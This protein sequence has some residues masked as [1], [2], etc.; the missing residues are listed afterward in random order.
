MAAPED[1]Q[2]IF[3]QETE[4]LIIVS[5]YY[6]AQKGFVKIPKTGEEARQSW[7]KIEEKYSYLLA[8]HDPTREEIWVKDYIK[9]MIE[10]SEIIRNFNQHI[11]EYDSHMC[12]SH[13][14]SAQITGIRDLIDDLET[15]ELDKNLVKGLRKKIESLGQYL[16][17]AGSAWTRA[18]DWS[19]IKKPDRGADWW[20]GGKRSLGATSNITNFFCDETELSQLQEL[21]KYGQMCSQELIEGG[22]LDDDDTL[23]EDFTSLSEVT[24]DMKGWKDYDGKFKPAKV[25]M[26]LLPDENHQRVLGTPSKKKRLKG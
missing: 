14:L 6:V 1:I 18:K 15:T 11:R 26:H 21:C 19:S 20:Y 12:K 23:E 2:R 10:F 24:K 3:L 25:T 13:N 8:K 7:G 22:L 17:K 5:D 16:W 4:Q 9:S